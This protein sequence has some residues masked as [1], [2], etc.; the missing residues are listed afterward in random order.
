[1][2]SQGIFRIIKVISS[3]LRGRSL[4]EPKLR[5]ESSEKDKRNESQEGAFQEIWE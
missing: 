3:I 5:L 2:S 1:M 4:K